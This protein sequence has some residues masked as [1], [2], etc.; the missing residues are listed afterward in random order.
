[1]PFTKSPD[2]EKPEGW[3]M[4]V[5]SYVVVE[6]QSRLLQI[7]T[8]FG[9]QDAWDCTVWKCERDHLVPTTGI[10]IFNSKLVAALDLAYRQGAPMA[11][12][13]YRGGRNGTAV[14][15]KDDSSPTMTLLEKFWNGGQPFTS[16]FPYPFDN[17]P[18]AKA[19]S[20]KLAEQQLVAE[21][22]QA[23]GEEAVPTETTAPAVAV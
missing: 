14:V 18:L 2:F 15:L 10:R 22:A 23:D 16:D 12:W 6:P 19:Y 5:G 8:K 11:G 9:E 20:D 4:F 21:L 3:S 7:K 13:V 17:D 1:M